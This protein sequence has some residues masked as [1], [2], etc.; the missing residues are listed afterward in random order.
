MSAPVVAIARIDEGYPSRPPFHPGERYPE[1]RGPTG[2]EPNPVFAGVRR[3]LQN[4]R[5]DESRF[6][7]PRWNPLGHLI[8]PGQTVF[9]KPNMVDH[10]HRFG[11]D[12]WSV[13]THPA[14][15]WVVAEYVAIALQGRGRILIGDNPHVDCQFPELVRHYGVESLREHLKATHGIALKLVDL[16]H[17]HT[18]D[19]RYYG[20]QMGRVSLPGDPRGTVAVD[21]GSRSMLEGVPWWL[22]RGTYHERS[23]TIRAHLNGRH[24]YEFSR[25]IFDS[26]VFISIPKLKAHAKVGATLNIKGLIGTIANKNA[27]V[28]WRLGFPALG[29]DE[30]PDPPNLSDYAR[31]YTQHAL[32]VGLPSYLYFHLRKRL[33]HTPLGAAYRRVTT[34]HSQRLRMLRG[35]WEG[36][37]TIWRMTADVYNAFVANVTGQRGSMTLFSVIDGVTA[38][39]T[40]GP[41]FPHARD[42]RILLAGDDLLAVDLVALRLMDFRLRTVRHLS[43]LATEHGLDP[44]RITVASDSWPREGFFDP[45]R[46]HLCFQPPHRWPSL[47]LHGIA[48]GPSYLPLS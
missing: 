22:L 6:D 41:H 29:G 24:R 3:L 26:D 32:A 8:R 5:Y 15:V 27:L 17:W 28:H 7:T 2:P 10:E 34:C 23:E 31:L 37:D 20:F 36:N 38:G 30:Y 35:A 14:V 11:G 43:H 13:V 4:L 25:S 21:L 42:A 45:Q 44:R 33:R 47:S 46:L 16:R 19:L 18:P 48:P 9:I 12:L 1:V 40:D 39:E